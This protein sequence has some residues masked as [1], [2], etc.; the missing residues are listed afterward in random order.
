MVH[1]CLITQVLGSQLEVGALIKCAI[2]AD[3]SVK[4][5]THS[6]KLV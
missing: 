2:V 6:D 4:A 1:S 3:V 5:I